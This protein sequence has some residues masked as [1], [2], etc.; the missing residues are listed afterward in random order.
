MDKYLK[1][2]EVNF[3]FDIRTSCKIKSFDYHITKPW[4]AYVTQNNIFAL[5]DYQRKICLKSFVT[6]ILD[7]APNDNIMISLSGKSNDLKNLKFLDKEILYWLYPSSQPILEKEND[8]LASFNKNAIIFFNEQKIVFYDYVTDHTDIIGPS[9]LENK[10]VKCISIMNHQY[11]LIGCVDGFIK[12][13]DM[14]A[15]TL[16]KTLK[17]YH[18]KSI[19]F[20]KSYKQNL[21]NRPKFIVSSNDGLMACW[22]I[23]L[24]NAP[25]FKFVMQKKGKQVNFL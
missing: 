20:I 6:S 16:A 24:E 15:W 13:F 1:G 2:Y 23:D 5:W 25:A 3:L 17:G 22:T 19:N 14:V 12:I 10:S 8:I 4:V 7:P 9:I 11:L 21:I 18:T